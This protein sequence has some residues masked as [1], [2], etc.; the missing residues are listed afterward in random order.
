MKILALEFSS[1]QR[2]VAILNPET[3]TIVEA[4]ETCHGHTMK[5]FGLIEDVL[6]QAQLERE[7]IEV[8]AVGL[9]PGSYTGIRAAIALAQGWQLAHGV[10]LCGKSSAE[11]LA[12][13]EAAEGL[14]KLNV[15]ID[16]Q[17]GEFY[18]ATYELLADGKLS[19]ISPLRIV[20]PETI[21]ARERAGEVVIGPEVTKWFPNGR[22]VFPHAA[23]LA[24]LAS[25]NPDFVPG[26]KLEPTYLRETTFV[27]AT[28]Y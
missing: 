9:G 12:N 27:K 6:R 21:K 14:T 25:T 3:G 26:E 18:L 5:P 2:S 22:Q 4:V 24:Q 8:V 28:G 10:K 11:C 7:Q 13:Q 1:P 17:R 19:A 15:V 20:A 16:A 23:A